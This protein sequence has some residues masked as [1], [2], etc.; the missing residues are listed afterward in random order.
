MKAASKKPLDYCH[1]VDHDQQIFDLRRDLG[2]AQRDARIFED[3]AVS[4]RQDKLAY[5]EALSV[6]L[7]QCH[8]LRLELEALRRVP[9]E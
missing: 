5:R 7:S 8:G 4:E 1:L 3:L 2:E 6:L 9:H